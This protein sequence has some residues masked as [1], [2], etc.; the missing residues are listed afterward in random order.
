MTLGCQDIGIRIFEFVAKTKFLF[1]FFGDHDYNFNFYDFNFLEKMRQRKF[2]AFFS[3]YFFDENF[4][5]I[6]N[7]FFKRT[8]IKIQK[9]FEQLIRLFK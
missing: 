6:K 3:T 4:L 7:Q 9:S 5:Q 8:I 1:K 2:P